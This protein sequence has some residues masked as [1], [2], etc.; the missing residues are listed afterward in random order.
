MA[1]TSSGKSTTTTA[2]PKR[3]RAVPVAIT[4]TVDRDAR[5][6]GRRRA[7]ARP[8]A[9]GCVH[10]LLHR[11]HRAEPPP[12]PG[13]RR[14]GRGRACASRSS[15]RRTSKATS[16]A[17]GCCS[18][19]ST[20][21]CT[22]SRP[23][24][25]A[26]YGLDRLWG[27][28]VPL[29]AARRRRPP[30][31]TARR[32]EAAPLMLRALAD[33]VLAAVL[34]PRCAVCV[35]G[36]RTSARR[37]GL[38]R[39]LGAGHPLHA[40]LVRA[41]RRAAGQR[42][43]SR[44]AAGAGARACTVGL[45]VIAA[46]RAVGPFDGALAD[47]V[48]AFKYGRRPSIGR[49]FGP[50]LARGRGRP[51]RRHR[52]R[53]AGAAAS[54]T[55]ARARLQSGGAAGRGRGPAACAGR[56]RARSHTAPQVAASGQ[57]RWANVRGAFAPGRDFRRV[58]RPHGGAGRRRAHHRSHAVG[59]RRGAAAGRPRA[60][61]GAYS[62]PSRA[63]TAAATSTRTASGA[64]VAVDEVPARRLRLTA[65][66]GAHARQQRQVALEAI[67][68]GA[69]ALERGLGR[70]VEHEREVGRRQ[71]ALRVGR[72][73]PRRARAPRRRPGSRRR[74]DR[75]PPWRRPTASRGCA[76]AYS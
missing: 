67:A 35:D 15:G 52:P 29:V 41:L 75:P 47:I 24:A 60:D 61:R 69:L 40:P 5:Q 31:T 34:A 3:A 46:A 12:G 36:P 37:R 39:L 49:A 16:A 73:T 74:S 10:R 54:P 59:R 9:G 72:A 65:I 1:K 38:C 58:R 17:S 66:A 55:R 26:F 70:D 44:G 53:G 32:P 63:R 42:A 51:A 56:W 22:S 48:H 13:H 45:G 18:T 19:T 6:E 33:A 62:S 64:C 43:R 14:R 28:A 23:T 4:A 68:R 30:A 20:S 25:R 21:S 57:A 11:G 8:Q 2:A 76:A 50:L 7:G 71:Q 27:N